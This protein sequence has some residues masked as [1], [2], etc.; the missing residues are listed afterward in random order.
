MQR[1]RQL[2]SDIIK[3]ITGVENVHC[4]VSDP[5]KARKLYSLL[6]G[7]PQHEDGS[8]SEF[9]V[10][11][12]D[13]AVT[14]GARPKFVITFTVEKLVDLQSLLASKLSA[15]LEIRHGDHGDYIEVCP[16]KA[17]VSISLRRR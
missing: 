16:K 11:G 5:E 1:Q 8:W 15:G 6:F 14:L 10:G 12:L 13:V 4:F 2:Q 17:F 3:Y 9:K 7:P